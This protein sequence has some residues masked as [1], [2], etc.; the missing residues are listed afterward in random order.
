M[1]TNDTIDTNYTNYTLKS[2][3]NESYTYLV[4][5]KDLLH[6]I[7]PVIIFV[8]IIYGGISIY[9]YFH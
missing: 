8:S 9:L 5:I 3:Y 7:I 2:Y 6:L 4:C 1:I